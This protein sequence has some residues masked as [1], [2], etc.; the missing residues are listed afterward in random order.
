MVKDDEKSAQP[1]ISE[2]TQPQGKSW[3]SLVNK[4][5]D[6]A[7]GHGKPKRPQQ[8]DNK[9]NQNAKFSTNKKFKR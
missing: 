7:S 3:T 6:T 4:V 5:K 8:I 9:P 1:Q 2:I